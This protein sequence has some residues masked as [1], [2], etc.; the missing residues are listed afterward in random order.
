MTTPTLERFLD[1]VKNHEASLIDERFA[2][3]SK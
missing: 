1:D 2:L 3:G